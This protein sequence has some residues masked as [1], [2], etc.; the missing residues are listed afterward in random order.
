MHGTAIQ[1]YCQ[2]KQQKQS[3]LWLPEFWFGTLLFWAGQLQNY[4]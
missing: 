2:L 1:A 3:K 4:G